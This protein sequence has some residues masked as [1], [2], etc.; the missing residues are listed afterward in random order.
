MLDD[1]VFCL[2]FLICALIVEIR[3]RLPTLPRDLS[4]IRWLFAWELGVVLHDH[5][6]FYFVHGNSE[7]VYHPFVNESAYDIAREH[8]LANYRNLCFQPII[9]VKSSSLACLVF[10]ILAEWEL[11]ALVFLVFVNFQ[12][13]GDVR[14]TTLNSSY[15]SPSWELTC[16]VHSHELFV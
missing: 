2:K 13:N 6:L 3:L 7:E 4:P 10:G 14:S 1:L 12:N 8:Y 5:Q 11:A 16:F 15:L 9:V